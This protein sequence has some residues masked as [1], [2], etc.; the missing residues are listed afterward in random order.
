MVPDIEITRLSGELPSELNDA[1]ALII[2]AA[3]AA[4]DADPISEQGLAGFEGRI[5]AEHVVATSGGVPAGIATIRVENGTANIEAVVDPARRRQ[6]IGRTLIAAAATKGSQ[7]WAHGD[8]PAAASLAKSLGMARVREL[9]QMRRSLGP[10]APLPELTVPDGLEVRTYAGAED[11]AEI[12]RVNNAAFHWHPEQGGWSISDVA[13]RKQLSWFD[14]EGL[15]LAFDTSAP[16]RLLGFHWTKTH[17]AHPPEP[18]FGE[19]YIVGVDPAVHGRGLGRLLTLRGLHSLQEQGLP[20]VLLYVEANNIAALRTYEK[21]G[22][23]RH[24]TD[25]AYVMT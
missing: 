16:D 1:V 3:R 8:L 6:G 12:V 14:P 17:G 9:L 10:E 2:A 15:F 13:A 23:H 19:V 22:F 7:L 4:D 11:D 5:S 18:P 25:V 20:A 21:L 24:F